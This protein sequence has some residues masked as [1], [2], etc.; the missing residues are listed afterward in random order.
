ML[1]LVEPSRPAASRFGPASGRD[2]LPRL[3]RERRR[4]FPSSAP[5]PGSAWSR[6][7]RSPGCGRS[8]RSPVAGARR[9]RDG[10]R[11]GR[12]RERRGPPSSGQ[13]PLA[14]LGA[15]AAL[16]LFVAVR[17]AALLG[18]PPL[19]RILAAT[20]ALVALATALAALGALAPAGRWRWPA[21]A[22]AALAGLARAALVLGVPARMLLPGGWDELGSAAAGGPRSG[23]RRE[24]PLPG[25]GDDWARLAIMLGLP[26]VV[27]A[28]AAI[29]FWPSAAAAKARAIAGLAIVVGAYGTAATLAPPAAPLLEGLGLFAL[30][31][32]WLWLPL[33]ARRNAA[34][35]LGLVAVAGL[36]A[37]PLCSGATGREPL[38]D[39]EQLGP[40]LGLRG[41]PGVLHLEPLLR[42]ARLAATGA[43]GC[44][45]CAAAAPLL[46]DRRPRPLR[47]RPLARAARPP[48]AHAAAAVAGREERLRRVPPTS[49]G[50]HRP[51]P[52]RRPQQPARG[53]RRDPAL[54]P[55]PWSDRCLRRRD[56]A[57]RR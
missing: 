1:A 23:G 39:Y 2:P 12:R 54:G 37:L 44:W 46:E 17:W 48:A 26:L 3:R 22:G 19:A 42:A 31:A 47:R 5:R 16:A 34:M 10:P 29:A 36:A 33:I 52:D 9:R 20:L 30:V 55:G 32:A 24:L 18:D 49:L 15:F 7:R 50:A 11:A 43:S 6:R 35:G 21:A 25:G 41:R 28:A 4:G 13:L 45:S 56:R 27:G 53:R 8:S 40:L 51:L 14:R 38:L 57:V